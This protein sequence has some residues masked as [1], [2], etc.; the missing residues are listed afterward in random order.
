MARP[1]LLNES[2]VQRRLAELPGWSGDS[3][4]IRRSVALPAE[5]L[6]ALLGEVDRVQAE[7]DHHAQIE[8]QDGGVTFVV[9][10][11]SAGGVTGLDF[12]LALRINA[13]IGG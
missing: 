12:E 8:Q 11:H 13:V 2:E 9:R 6:S 7:L 1:E 3:Q 4:R 10:T 5:R